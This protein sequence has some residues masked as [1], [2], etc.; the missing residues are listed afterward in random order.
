[1]S[2]TLLST[3]VTTLE[4]RPYSERCRRNFERGEHLL[5]GVSPGNS[6]FSADRIAE[7]VR[8]GR[9]FFASVDIVL[10][11]LHVDAQFL[12]S[13]HTPEQAMRR[14]DKEVKATRRR[15]HRGMAEAAR[16]GVRAHVLSDFLPDPGYQRLH[17]AVREALETDPELRAATEGMAGA[18]LR[19]R[20]TAADG[21]GADRLA[22]GV[23]YI[24]AELPFF[25]DTPSLLGVPSSVT[26]YHLELPL[27]PVLFGRTEGLR[28]AP[29]QG[30]AVVRPATA[31]RA[32]AA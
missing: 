15:I 2:E 16:D 1:M 21:P 23:A 7:L 10:A 20:I 19:S 25:L 22:A 9:D 14:A 32:A 8:W 17:R 26:C 18:F 31:P 28:A 12:A 29:A 13:G 30:Y 11:D 5:I 27:T 6:Y 4:A 24:A 3:T